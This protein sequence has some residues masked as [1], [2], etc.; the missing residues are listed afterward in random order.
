MQSLGDGWHERKNS[1]PINLIFFNVLR[2][3]II[4]EPMVYEY[5]WFLKFMTMLMASGKP[6]LWLKLGVK[7]FIVGKKCSNIDVL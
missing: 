7:V 6:S 1:K 4:R 3:V 2:L 5:G